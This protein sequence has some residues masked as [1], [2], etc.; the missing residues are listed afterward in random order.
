ME[1]NRSWQSCLVFTRTTIISRENFFETD[2]GLE[3]KGGATRFKKKCGHT[4]MNHHQAQHKNKMHSRCNQNLVDS[5]MIFEN[6]ARQV[7]LGSGTGFASNGEIQ[8]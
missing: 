6:R 7:D 1:D 5:M 3:L 8:Q 2:Q 4:R